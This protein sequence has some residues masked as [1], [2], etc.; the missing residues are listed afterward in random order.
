MA[1]NTK[2]KQH[3]APV[4]SG[5]AEKPAQLSVG[6]QGFTGYVVAIG[7]SAGGLDALER[8]FDEMSADSGAAIVVIQHLS[9]DHKSMMDNLLARHTEMPVLMAENGLSIQSAEVS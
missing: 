2:N 5:A 7:A 1:R 3:A 8:F 6:K 4:P 9:P